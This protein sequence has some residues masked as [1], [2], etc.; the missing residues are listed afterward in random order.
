MAD[1]S[2]APQGT[3]KN[4]TAATVSSNVALS[5]LD[6]APNS[7]NV[8]VF[9]S[10]SVIVFIEFGTSSS[11]AAVV[12]TSMPIPPGGVET[13]NAPGEVTYVAGITG[14]GGGTCYFTEGFNE[15]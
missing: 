12:A 1:D 3:T 15:S 9:N 5:V 2:F 14:A 8:R 6:V 7:R 10:T 13:F 4:I 11:V